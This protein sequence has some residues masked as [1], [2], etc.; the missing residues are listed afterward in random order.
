VYTWLGA[1][2]AWLLGTALQLMSAPP[3]RAGCGLALAVGAGGLLLAMAG[4]RCL[5][6]RR[7]AD[8]CPGWRGAGWRWSVAGQVLAALGLACLAWGL[9]GWRALDRLA[10]AWPSDLAHQVVQADVRWVGLPQ[11]LPAPGGGVRWRVDADVLRWQAP[12]PGAGGASW[13]QRVQL[14]WERPA[15]DG[16]PRPGEAW[17]LG[18]R[19]RAPDELVN[20]GVGDGALGRFA[21]G[22]R[23]VGRVVSAQA[24]PSRE[25]TWLDAIDAWRQRVRD[26]ILERIPDPR[27]AGVLAGLSVGDQAAISRWKRTLKSEICSSWG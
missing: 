7:G 22:V 12:M 10:Q 11:R 14:F 13:P 20:P 23:A 4:R 1:S 5:P 6:Q 8:G 9:T 25:A 21:R 16:P 27:A 17:R 24:L 26:R 2:L 3:T 15:S 18:M 19:L